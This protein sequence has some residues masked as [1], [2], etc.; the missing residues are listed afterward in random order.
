MSV[1][2]ETPPARAP[3]RESWAFLQLLAD[4]F[5]RFPDFRAWPLL[6][7]L[8]ALVPSLHALDPNKSIFQF[9]VQNWTRQTGLPS[10]KVNSVTQ[11]KDGY[12][13]LG[14]QAGLVRFDGR[15]FKVVPIDLPEARGLEVLKSSRAPDGRLWFAV[16]DGGFGGFDGEHFSP[17]GD[18]RWN[19]SDILAICILAARDGAIW[20]GSVSGWG[21]WMAGKPQETFSDETFGTVISLWEDAAGRVWLGTGEHGLLYWENGGLKL[22]PDEEL[23]RYNIYSIVRDRAGD[24]WVA[25][26]GGLFHYDAAFHRKGVS[27]PDLQTNVLLV[28]RQGVLWAGTKGTGLGRFQD[29]KFTMLRKSDG[30]ASDVVTSLFEDA[31]G[32]LWVGTLEGVSQLSDLK[33]PIYSA[34][35]GLPGGSAIAVAASSRGGLWIGLAEGASYFDG[36]R[37][38]NFADASDLPNRYV[39]RIFEARNGDVY[40]A[41]GNK[42]INIVSAGRIVARC[43]N[44]Q[45]PEALVEDATGVIAAIGPDLFRIR[46]GRLEPY[47]FDGA[48][49]TF[50][51]FNTLCVAKDGAIWAATNNGLFRIEDGR[52]KNWTVAEGLS[53][54]RVN[55]VFEDIDG[56]IWCG[57]PTGLVRLK[58]NEI[59]IVT[60]ADG[61]ADARIYAIV[62][63]DLGF[64]WLYSGRGILRVARKSLAEFAAD[65]SRRVACD[66]FDGLE[67]VKFTDRTDQ[68]FSGCKTPDGRIWFPN[69]AGV[70]MVDPTHYFIN[71]VPPRVHIESVRANGR[72]LPKGQSAVLPLAERSVEFFFS[73]LSFIAP[74]KV[75]VRYQLE[76]FDA[77]WVGADLNRSVTYNNLRSGRYTF[78]VQAAN[79]DGVWN[80]AGDRFSIELP[81]PYYERPSF[82]ALCGGALA[83]AVFGGYRWKLRQLHRR[84]QKLQAENDLLEAKVARRTDEL[85]RSFSVLNATIES[86]ADG[87][88]VVDLAGRIIHYNTR[89][90]GIWQYPGSLLEHGDAENFRAH[91]AQLLK[92]PE[93]FLEIIPTRNDGPTASDFDEIA[94]KD[95]RIFERYVLPQSIEGKC[96]GHVVNWRDVTTRKHAESELRR[97]HQQLLVASRQAGMAEVATGVL[98]NVGNVLNS[99]NVSA[100]LVTDQVRHSKGASVAK[101]AALFAEHRADLGDFLTKDARG[102][103]IPD[104]LGMLAD[105]LVAEQQGQLTELEHLRKSI[106][107]IK[108]IVAMQQAHA[109]SSGV[110]ETVEVSDLVEAAIQMNASSLARHDITLFR[111]YQTRPM[112][113]TDKHRVI[114]IL[115]NLVRNAKQACDESGRTDKQIAVRT[116]GDDR[117]VKI[118]VS[119]NGVGIPAEN[120]DRI[121]NQGFTTK[122][123]GHGFGLH[124]SAIAA[125]E[126]GGSLTVQSGGPGRGAA[127]ILDLP[128]K[129]NPPAHEDSPS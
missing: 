79:A 54:N 4:I 109:G 99:V 63:D 128:L 22:F 8:A 65:R 35:E 83:L 78:R 16:G 19:A 15:E 49:P 82:Y 115:I 9:N 86:T 10:D 58:N 45:W 105:S 24:L 26:N 3:K 48:A 20:T 76:G 117:S 29:G 62:P 60:S 101:L 122:K 11:T 6:C 34:K 21:R 17:I 113:T 75:N 13:W 25:T 95:G 64:F 90:A 112:I 104:Y 41:D 66:I 103:M 69:P 106:E 77:A 46:D 126:I 52:V 123:T 118:T 124:N 61:L 73:A 70:V 87:I 1:A 39:R 5:R 107:H 55:F 91:A 67:S 110:I 84:Q 127:F 119:D 102:Q 23:K 47:R 121:F 50:G 111:D 51:W 129:Q 7:G 30:L 81:P 27:F 92:D 38:T 93:K 74:T 31:E 98:H 108:D 44:G 12:L 33:F 37:F 125:K 120:L 18:S 2:P 43:T 97:I 89:F 40:L 56:S 96:V 42:N 85:A 14:T 53:S 71:R 114:Q 100:T 28:D 57:L 72:I 32:S 36:G 94:L 116:T 88:V 80:T 68:G 59:T